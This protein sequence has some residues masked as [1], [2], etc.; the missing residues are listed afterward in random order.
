MAVWSKANLYIIFYLRNCYNSN[1]LKLQKAL[2]IVITVDSLFT[3]GMFLCSKL[4]SQIL[5][6]QCY[7][8]WDF[9]SPIIFIFDDNVTTYT[10]SRYYYYSEEGQ[11]HLFHI[12]TLHLTVIA[13][14]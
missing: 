5:T 12:L 4:S 14:L 9:V 7:I 10:T 3:I 13:A 6:M 1:W 11:S 2:F 8:F